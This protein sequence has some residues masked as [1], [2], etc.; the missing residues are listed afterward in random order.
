MNQVESKENTIKLFGRYS[1]DDIEIND[2]SL[3]PYINVHTRV[4]VPHTGV[5]YCKKQFAKANMPLTMR[6]AHGLMRHGRNT[7]KALLVLKAVRD[8]FIIIERLTKKN[9]MQILVDA[10]INSGPREST[11]RVGKGGS[12]KR[13]SVDVSPLRRLNLAIEFLTTGMRKA[14]FKNTK[15]LPETIADELIAASRGNPNAYA[16]KKRDEVERVAKSSR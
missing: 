2:V 16:V 4:S 9:P 1:Y 10:C 6:L 11:A 14:A 7:S 12:A 5:S 15:T 8:A 13:S 3:K